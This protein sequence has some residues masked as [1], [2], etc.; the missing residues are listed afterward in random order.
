MIKRES[1]MMQKTHQIAHAALIGGAYAAITIV[2]APISYGVVQV[3][4]SEALTV[5]PYVFGPYAA[6]G[7]FIGCLFSETYCPHFQVLC[8]L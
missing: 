8:T 2:L 4:A 7:L 6:I 1:V 3:R 5:L